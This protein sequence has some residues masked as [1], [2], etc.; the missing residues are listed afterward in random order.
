MSIR[1]IGRFWKGLEAVF[2]RFLLLCL[3]ALVMIAHSACQAEP[4]P[5]P[6]PI[7][8]PTPT[9]SL[10]GAETVARE[11]LRAWQSEDYARM[12]T[13]L[14]SSAM[15]ATPEEKFV[16]RYRAIAT[17]ATMTGLTASVVEI[18]RAFTTTAQV[19]F[20]LTIDTRLVGQFQ[21]ENVLD[22]SYDGQRWGVDWTPKAIFPLL[23]W[24]NLVHMFIHVPARGNIYDRRDLPLAMEGK[25][26]EIGVVPGWIED[27]ARLLSIL[28]K[29]LGLSHEAIKAKYAQA[30]RPD[31][32][33]PVGD[34]TPEVKQA[35]EALLSSEPGITWRDKPIR[36]YPYGSLA[37]QVVG[38]TTLIDAET[39]ARL[40]EQGYRES[41]WIGVAGLEGWGESYL[42]GTRGGTLAIISPD[43]RI[44]WTLA[45]RPA[46]VSKSIYT[47]LDMD[48]QRTVEGILG[49]QIG[50]IVV[51]D[52][53]N[54]EVL[55]MVS[56][57]GYDPNIFITGTAQQR[58]AL[59]N[60][61][62][63]PFLN[64]AIAGLYPPGSTFKIVT[65]SA[66]MQELGLT[67]HS[68][69]YCAGRW[70]GLADGATRYCWLSSGHGPLNLLNGLVYSC[71][72][73]FWEIGKALNERDPYALPRWARAFG[74]GVPT[75]LNA[76]V[77][78]AGL[79]ADPDWKAQHYSGTEQ[80]WLPR[81]AVNMAIG[82][83]D[84]LVTPLQMA[85][86]VA[87]V[88]NGGTLYQPRLVRLIGSLMGDDV[89]D[90][91]PQVLGQL[92]I[93]SANL[94]VV[95]RA[96]EGVVQ[97]GTASRAFIG[98]TIRMAGK[99]GTAEAPPGD[100]HAWF[101][102]YAPADD[103]QIAVAVVLERGGEGGRNAAPLFRQV[104]EAYMTL[105]K[106]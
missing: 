95:R 82:Q 87:A 74:L 93:S 24:D 45:E 63:K 83:G 41:D 48:L 67:Q 97:Y 53:R 64:R 84:V 101:V 76:L 19:T 78:A 39:L 27:E 28:S 2:Q 106:R 61:P 58:I 103:P 42:S 5:I 9:P 81:D 57:P 73:V 88:A 79:I 52:V 10:I 13:F 104:V 21:V 33:M 11:Y 100:P 6:T 1:S 43:G 71:D 50:A 32:F 36:V 66:G 22:L 105:S 14:S 72:T 46:T 70:D 96:M 86:L 44:V 90:F 37:A 35:N 94:Q 98:A 51:L 8:T 34:I 47:T 7:P 91:P 12:Y 55:A 20:T 31:W 54:G 17:E 26:I 99:S 80:R 4:S 15:A 30:A 16:S 29:L 56:H 75:G 40:Q 60:D 69:F 92:P 49:Q 59:L 23:V 3:L 38:Y 85:N 89:Q 68:T 77:E 18:Q 62:G 102:G 25:L 65:M